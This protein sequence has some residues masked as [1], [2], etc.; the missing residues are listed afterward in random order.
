MK[1]LLLVTGHI[2]TFD[3]VADQ[4]I[5][6]F[7]DYERAYVTWESERDKASI[8]KK[9]DDAMVHYVSEPEKTNVEQHL[10]GKPLG[11]LSHGLEWA[12][13]LSRQY[14]LLDQAKVWLCMDYDNVARIRFDSVIFEKTESKFAIP[15]NKDSGYHT[16]THG[17]G[18]QDQVCFA[19]RDNMSRYLDIYNHLPK[20]FDLGV[21]ISM[22]ENLWHYYLTDYL[23][24]DYE[25]PTLRYDIV[26]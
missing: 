6:L 10:E 8:I 26:R 11:Q 15:M 2:R 21:D 23:K 14:Y 3:K 7:G 4:N 18:V 5:K 19:D 16:P 17:Y 20:L 25:K 12:S 9:H 13:R 24:A 1:N 22:A